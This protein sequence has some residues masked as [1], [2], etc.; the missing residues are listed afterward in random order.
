[1]QLATATS[2]IVAL[3]NIGGGS[4]APREV[5]VRP[6]YPQKASPADLYFCANARFGTAADAM[7][8]AASRGL[9]AEI[10]LEE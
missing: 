2:L 4:G 1:M 10:Y 9:Q 8:A 3:P 6:L 7:R 5:R